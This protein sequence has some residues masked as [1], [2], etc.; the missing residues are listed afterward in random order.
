MNEK[1]F[2]ECRLPEKIHELVATFSCLD[3]EI[4]MIGERS[5]CS[6]TKLSS[7]SDSTYLNDVSDVDGEDENI[8]EDLFIF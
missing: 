4:C 6:S 3:T 5:E 8:D 1:L 7:G 2:L